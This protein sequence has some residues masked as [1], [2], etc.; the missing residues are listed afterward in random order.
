[1]AGF[2]TLKI[3]GAKGTTITLQHT[4]NVCAQHPGKKT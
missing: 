3:T 2:T 4:E 1:M